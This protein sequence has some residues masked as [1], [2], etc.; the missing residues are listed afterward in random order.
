M[1]DPYKRDRRIGRWRATEEVLLDPRSHAAII[2]L[3][4]TV[5]V[6]SAKSDWP[7]RTVEF[8]GIS[9]HFDIVSDGAIPPLYNPVFT[10]GDG[11]IGIR[12]QRED[13]ATA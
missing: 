10:E 7:T 5:V 3:Q 1:A 8:A 2:K 13:E 11:G 12:W 6:L 4:G 9:E